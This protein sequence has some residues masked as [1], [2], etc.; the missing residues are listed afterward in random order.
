MTN[1]FDDLDGSCSFLVLTDDEGRHS[2]WPASAATPD[3]WAV[4]YGPYGRRGCLEYIGAHWVDMR[5]RSLPA[6]A[7][8]AGPLALFENWAARTPEALAVV[9]GDL[10]LSYGELNA[11]ADALAGRLAARGVGPEDLVALLVPRS[12]DLVVALLAALKCGAAYVPVD[13]EYPAER[14]AYVLAD[15]APKAVLTTDVTSPPPVPTDVPRLTLSVGDDSGAATG[16]GGPTARRALPQQ[17]AYVIYT[18]GSTGR[19]KG[20]VVTRAALANFLTAMRERFALSPAD[21]LVAVTTIAFDIAALEI[22]LPL[23][24]GAAVVM[25]SKETV[26]DPFA[27]AA[28][29]DGCGATTLQATPSLWQALVSDVPDAVRGLRMLVGGEALPAALGTRMRRLGREV[30]NLYGPTETTIWST[31]QPVDGSAPAACIGRPIRNTRAYVLDGE[32]RPVAAGQSGELYL[33]G[34]GLARG[35]LHRPELTAQR[36]VADP[37]GPRGTRMYRTGDLVRRAEDGS[38]EYLSRVDF[39]VKVRGFRI[40]PGEIENVLAGHPDVAQAA[41]TVREDR[42][43]DARLV[44]HVVPAAGA[45]VDPAALR[46]FA[47]RILPEHMVPSAV[48]AV[49]AFPLTPNGKLDRRALAALPW[50]DDRGPDTGEELVPD[51]SPLGAVAAAWRRILPVPPRRGRSFASL[52][53]TSLGAARAAAELRALTGRAVSVAD[54][55]GAAS[56]EQLALTVAA[57]PVHASRTVATGTGRTRAPLSANQ[58]AIWIHEQLAGDP[59]LYLETYCLELDGDLAPARL[60]EAFRKTVAQHPVAGAAVEFEGGE[61]HLVLGRHHVE[62]TVRTAPPNLTANQLSPL[63]RQEAARPV[64]LGAGPLLRGVLFVTA[65][66]RSVLLLSWHHLI[67]DGWGLRLFLRDLAHFHNTPEAQPDTTRPTVCDLNTWLNEAA[68]GPVPGRA[69]T[70]AVDHVRPAIRAAHASEPASWSAQGAAHAVE[71]RLPDPLARRVEQ[72]AAAAGHTAFVLICA[73]YQRALTAVLALERP[74]LAVAVAGRD[75]P[76]SEE[77]VGSFI[78]TVL[79]DCGQPPGAPDGPALL[80]HTRDA[81]DRALAAGADVPFPRLVNKLRETEPLAMD[82]PRLYLSVD[83]EPTAAF[84]GLAGRAVPTNPDRAK[85]AVT[86]SLLRG[87]GRLSGRL[88][89]RTSVLAPGDADRLLKAFESALDGLASA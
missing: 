27:L 1:P 7:A 75:I 77:V 60:S 59:L 12:T 17:P 10:R 69:L 43:G 24:S 87:A 33:A 79:L 84:D 72:A 2:L 48:A 64:P 23:L 8:D 55:L 39:Q 40:E 3:G 9:C 22:F 38:L 73:A 83:D 15:A 21:R 54:V 78:N 81:F 36:F 6:E 30:T 52:G 28:L 4:A 80:D 57:A 11:R 32:L 61:P 89:Y 63:V 41:V 25:A 13:P 49:D 82:F 53:G 85:F 31:A 62:L 26:R 86:L 45:A 35:Y 50:A 65:G 70:R 29:I 46:E 88:E 18:S 44:C 16:Y 51:D 47:G 56:A 58:R 37:F 20:V 19:P 42:P 5:P 68:S 66:P 74:L 67:M 71:F 76:E 34:D 14:I